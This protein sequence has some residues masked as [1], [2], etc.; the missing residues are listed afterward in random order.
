MLLVTML[1]SLIREGSLTLIDAQGRRHFFGSASASATG[2]TIRVTDRTLQTW[3]AINPLLKLG[4]AFADGKLVIEQGTLYEFLDLCARNLSKHENLSSYRLSYGLA[5]LQRLYNEYN[6]V[7]R[8]RQNVAHHYD[9]SGRLY[10]LFLDDD[11]QYSCAYFETPDATLEQAQLAKKRHLASKLL[12]KPGQKV[13]DIGCGWGGMALYLARLTEVDVTGITLSTEQLT[14]ARRRALLAGL[15]DRVHFDLLDYRNATGP[16]DRIISV[17]M[18][19]HVGAPHYRRFFTKLRDLLTDDGVAVLHAIGQRDG[20][21]PINPWIK[22]YIFPGA[23][24]PALSE[25]V[26]A[27]EKAGL[28]VTDI[29]ILRLHYA[30][31]LR[32]WRLRFEANRKT[33]ASI[34]DERFCRMW[35]FYLV[36]CEIG[37][38]TR[39]NMVFQIQISK[40]VD[41]VP[42]TRDYMIKAERRQQDEARLQTPVAALKSDEV[43][44]PQTIPYHVEIPG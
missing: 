42:L 41:T 29:E 44:D 1:R 32:H 5:A 36:L 25:V 23:Y 7:E 27:I 43:I 10:D 31:T 4:E 3:I 37:F 30:E 39:G 20:P 22:K 40:Q 16:F 34:Y 35:E 15:D 26:R 6:P 12:L 2:I 17:G 24:T 8:S 33:I 11:R 28:W 38:R 13:L 19:E 14:L 18:F 9:L 21:G